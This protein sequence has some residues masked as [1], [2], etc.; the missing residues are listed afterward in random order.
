MHVS[1]IA[2]LDKILNIHL[3]AFILICICRA[4]VVYVSLNIMGLEL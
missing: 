4:F 3:Q 2:N 1:I